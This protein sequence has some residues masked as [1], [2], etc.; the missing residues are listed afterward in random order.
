ME[1]FG[2]VEVAIS[3]IIAEIELLLALDQTE[4]IDTQL[5]S[6]FDDDCL[7]ASINGLNFTT[8][9]FSLSLEKL[10]LEDLEGTSLDQDVLDLVNNAVGLFLAQAGD[11]LPTV[12]GNLVNGA[13]KDELNEALN[14]MIGDHNTTCALLPEPGEPV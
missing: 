5:G 8:L 7:M 4:L 13:V 1:N 11:L 3:D 6:L 2:R 9:Q 10:F 14:E 12:L